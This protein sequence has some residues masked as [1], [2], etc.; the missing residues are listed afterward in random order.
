MSASGKEVKEGFYIIKRSSKGS[1]GYN[2][3][4]EAMQY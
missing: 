3:I 4:P 1:I 2:R